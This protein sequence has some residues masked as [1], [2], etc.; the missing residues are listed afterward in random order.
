MVSRRLTRVQRA[1]RYLPAH[2]GEKKLAV[3][4]NDGQ[5]IIEFMVEDFAEGFVARQFGGNDISTRFAGSVQPPE[6]AM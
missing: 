5:G 2:F 4:E 3:P 6:R 1:A